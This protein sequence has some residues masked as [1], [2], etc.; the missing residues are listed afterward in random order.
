MPLLQ[1]RDVSLPTWKKGYSGDPSAV[2]VIKKETSYHLFDGKQ[3]AV[4]AE[5]VIDGYC[6]GSTIV[7][8]TGV[9]RCSSPFTHSLVCLGMCGG[10]HPG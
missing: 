4:P 3:T 2:A 8:V 7:P 6:Y 9:W 1:V 5:E 10:C